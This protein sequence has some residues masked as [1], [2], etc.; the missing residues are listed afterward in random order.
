MTERTDLHGTVALVTGGAVGIGRHIAVR[1]AED[2]ADVA[3]TY[4]SH[5]PDETL[6]DIR[7]L[8]R[9]GHAIKVDATDPDA[10][11]AAV[12]DVVQ[13]LGVVA[14][15]VNNAGGLVGRIPLADM[16][17]THWHQVLELNLSS[18]FFFLRATAP[19][20]PDGGRVINIGS[21]AGDNGGSAGAG[22]Y[23]V[24]KAGLAG[25]TRAAAKEFA[26]AG[27]TVNA[28]A[29]GFI[30]QTPFHETFSTPEAVDAMT[31]STAVGR[32][33]AP[34]EVAHAVSFLASARAGF[35]TG[36]VLDL[37]GGTYFT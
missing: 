11:T 6:A 18:A 1:L 29:P 19:Q 31:K 27:I 20:M 34:S 3:I 17:T 4:L 9:R 26:S 14:V 24:A 36:A 13:Q 28:V 7:A 8:G 10:V 15:L 25:L 32:P 12:Q 2:G 5:G 22:A 30:D 35:I 33:G 16:S 23:A 37:N 21:L